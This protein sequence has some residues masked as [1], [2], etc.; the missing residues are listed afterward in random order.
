V[1]HDVPPSVQ[2]L[3]VRQPKMIGWIEGRHVERKAE[4]IEVLLDVFQIRITVIERSICA[5]LLLNNHFQSRPDSGRDELGT[6]SIKVATET[7]K[8]CG[9]QEDE[10]ANVLVGKTR[11]GSYREM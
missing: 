5:K 6:F 3:E 1:G 8:M 9:K 7:L 4:T 10:S 11:A 2:F